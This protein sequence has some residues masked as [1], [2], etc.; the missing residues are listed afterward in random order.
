MAL[1]ARQNSTFIFN[2]CLHFNL[3][4]SQF[5]I[6]V[7]Q[8]NFDPSQCGI[9][10]LTLVWVKICFPTCLLLI[11]C[12]FHFLSSDMHEW[13]PWT[14]NPLFFCGLLKMRHFRK[15]AHKYVI[16]RNELRLVQHGRRMDKECDIATL[17]HVADQLI[18]IAN[19]GEHCTFCAKVTLAFRQIAK[20]NR[21]VEFQEWEKNNA[22]FERN[23]LTDF[24]SFMLSTS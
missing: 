12:Q 4:C 7:S 15:M 21:V 22:T 23:L 14:K 5:D 18:S 19:E 11:L 6:G 9:T 3:W 16:S 20:N 2:V 24:H 17:R 8:R 10:F 1:Y 13:L